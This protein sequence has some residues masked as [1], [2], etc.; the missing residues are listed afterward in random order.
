MSGIRE[1]RKEKLKSESVQDKADNGNKNDYN[2][3]L[4]AHKLKTYAVIAGVAVLLIGIIAALI[5]INRQNSYSKYVIENTIRRTDSGYAEYLSY[6]DGFVRCSRDGVAY[7]TF[8]GTQKWNKPHE[9]NNMS[10]V[11]RDDYFAVANIGANEIHIFNKSGYISTV[12]TNLPIVKISISNQGLVVAILE[13]KEADYINMYDRNGEKVYTIKTTVE[14]NGIPTDISVSPDGKKLAVAF[15]SVKGLELST[16]VVF[17]NFDEV[18]QNENERIVGGFDSYKDQ[19]V[20]E[21]HFLN[22]RDVVAVAENVI[23]FYTVK[24]YPKLIKNIDISDEIRQVFYSENNFGYIYTDSEDKSRVMCV[25]DSAGN[26]LFEKT[27]DEK[28][29]DFC[30]TESGV[31]MYGGKEF[32]LMNNKGKELTAMEFETEISEI[33]PTEGNKDYLYITTDKIYKIK[34]K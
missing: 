7:Y 25:M 28:Y 6:E 16:S 9:I 10:I 20:G 24:E 12:N 11:Q 22:A 13:D 2:R 23:S 19:L 17:Y 8:G 21:V 29:S 33:I 15:T 3:K 34:F 1:Y 27:I 30:F 31:M 5:V 32:V 14:S 26:R 18:G 4:Q